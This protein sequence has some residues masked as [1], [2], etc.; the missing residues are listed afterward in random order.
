M[1]VLNRELQHQIL[2]KLAEIY[3]DGLYDLH[4]E[5]EDG[6]A[7]E[8]SRP[9][10]ATVQYLDSHELVSS[11]YVLTELTGLE[12]WDSMGRT[13]ITAKGLDF[14]A[15]DGGLSAILGTVTVRIDAAQFT[16]LLANKVEQ[17]PNIN[18]DERST[19]ASELRKLP[20]KSAEKV[21][22]KLLDWAVDHAGDALPLLRSLLPLA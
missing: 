16:E 22:E 21:I 4:K 13:T 3:P 10:L 17:L 8:P 1:T 19:I 9:L 14:L 15:D 7:E 2:S 11:G 20:A 5:M 12:R 18:H 6:A